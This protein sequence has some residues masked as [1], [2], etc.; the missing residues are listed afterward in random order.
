MA[1]QPYSEY[2]LETLV[3]ENTSALNLRA[4]PSSTYDIIKRVG[5]GDRMTFLAMEGNWVKV[6]LDEGSLVGYVYAQYVA[7]LR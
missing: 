7:V 2:Y 3:I 6:R 4:G 5:E 1:N